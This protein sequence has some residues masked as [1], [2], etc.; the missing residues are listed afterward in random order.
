[1]KNMV[2]VLWGI[3]L[4][5][6]TSAVYPSSE[7]DGHTTGSE[8]KCQR[9]TLEE[10][11]LLGDAVSRYGPKNW[12]KI[13]S[14]VP[15]R[16]SRQCRD[17]WIEY[18]DPTLRHGDWTEEEDQLLI[19]QRQLLGNKWAKIAQNF[20][21]RTGNEIKNRWYSRFSKRKPPNPQI[22]QPPP[23]SWGT[24]SSFDFF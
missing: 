6:A 19:E 3:F 13:A 22:N 15:N 2:L 18:L 7:S 1:M 8:R 11:R 14:Q 17:R 5:F 21:N 24:V 12:K 20:P 10:D 9:W 23:E 16:T 4:M